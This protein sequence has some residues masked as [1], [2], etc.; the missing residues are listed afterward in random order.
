MIQLSL[1]LPLS[2]A[3]QT[4]CP[5]YQSTMPLVSPSRQQ[6]NKYLGV[7]W[8][9]TKGT[10][11]PPETTTLGPPDPRVGFRP[12]PRFSSCVSYDGKN[13]LRGLRS[14][15]LRPE[16]HENPKGDRCECNRA[17]DSIGAASGEYK[18]KERNYFFPSSEACTMASRETRRANDMVVEAAS[19]SK[20]SIS[21]SDNLTSKP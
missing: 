13:P 15:G 11:Y 2:R 1:S 7:P 3:H 12:N 17:K 8:G 19:S 9:A 4:L 16:D 6:R 21:S 14:R 18:Q 20:A 10:T 5:D